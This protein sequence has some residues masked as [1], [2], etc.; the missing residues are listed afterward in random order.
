L[1]IVAFPQMHRQL[2]ELRQTVQVQRTESS[3][4]MHK[5]GGPST[6]EAMNVHWSK[7]STSI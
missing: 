3:K 5:M 1:P 6:W 2:A 7:V 4:R